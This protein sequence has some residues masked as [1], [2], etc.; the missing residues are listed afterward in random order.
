[1]FKLLQKQCLLAKNI[2]EPNGQKYKDEFDKKSAPQSIAIV[3]LVWYLDFMT[4]G[5]YPK[6]T[7]K[8]RLGL[9][10]PLFYLFIINF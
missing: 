7:L 2:S 9:S 3:K 6:L 4:I 8:K 5:K 10:Q 1:M